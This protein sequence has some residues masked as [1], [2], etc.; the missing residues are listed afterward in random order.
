MTKLTPE[1]IEQLQSE[2]SS[3]SDRPFLILPGNGIVMLSAPHAVEQTR[4]GRIKSAE[5]ETGIIALEINKIIGAPVII[6][7][8]NCGDDANNDPSSSYRHYLISYIKEN[9]I[10]FLIDLHQ[11]SSKRT[12]L[13]DLGVNGYR[14]FRDRGLVDMIANTFAKHGISG[15]EIDKPFAAS[16]RNTVSC[17]IS[18]KTGI[19]AIQIEI[20]SKLVWDKDGVDKSKINDVVDSLIEIIGELNER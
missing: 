18:R 3:Y 16:G 14:N 2:L 19:D 6:K 5:K 9:G 15:I 8:K 13:I 1:Y 10:K 20:N 17:D 4:D 11:L 7:T 12:V